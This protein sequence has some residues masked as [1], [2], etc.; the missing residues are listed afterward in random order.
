[1]AQIEIAEPTKPLRTRGEGPLVPSDSAPPALPALAPVPPSPLTAALLVAVVVLVAGLAVAYATSAGRSVPNAPLPAPN[2]DL[3][4]LVNP[5]QAIADPTVL[6]GKHVDYLYSSQEG[7]TPPNIPVR[8]FTTFGRWGPPRD[9]MPTIPAWAA[10]WIW[11]PDV[12]F[13]D[14]RYV[15]WF[16][17]SEKGVAL[18]MTGA[19]PR[20]LGWATSVAPLGPFVPSPRPAVC[21]QDEFGAIDPR[22][23]VAPGGQEWL[24]WKSD[25]N[26]VAAAD[27]PTMIWAQRLAGDGITLEGRATA[28]LADSAPWEGAI[29]ES[30]QMVRSHGRYYL[31]F[32][33][34]VSG[35]I[36]NGIGVSVCQ[37]PVGPCSNSSSGPW[38]GPNFMSQGVGEESL[39]TQNA[40]TWMVYSPHAPYQRLAVSRVAFSRQGPYLAAF[41]RL[42]SAG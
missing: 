13:A 14:G 28:I 34:N 39:F 41:G 25:D 18:P 32:S 31:F 9:A 38:L 10:P 15:M 11:N 36:D 5:L 37:S 23:F 16:T 1:V 20:C 22:T 24:Y 8:S 2:N 6:V 27:K 33:G 7:Y 4:R 29:V 35:S 12:T 17:A 19:M 40:V 21:Q 26:A 3:G 30:P 42:P